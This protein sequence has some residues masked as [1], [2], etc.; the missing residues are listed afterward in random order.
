MYIRTRKLIYT[1]NVGVEIDSL[2]FKCN[3][4]SLQM[5]MNIMCIQCHHDFSFGKWLK[6]I[7][8]MCAVCT[9]D[10]R[11]KKAIEKQQM[12]NPLSFATYSKLH[13]VLYACVRSTISVLWPFQNWMRP[14]E[15]ENENKKGP[16][17]I[18]RLSHQCLQQIVHMKNWLDV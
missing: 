14:R 15:W 7:Q 12:L 8:W 18:Y 4:V 3:K 9:G 13:T 5:V 11:K 2:E 1:V 17:Q 16:T 6:C 10:F